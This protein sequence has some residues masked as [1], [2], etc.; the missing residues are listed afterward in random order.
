[1]TRGVE[2]QAKR[3]ASGDTRTKLVIRVPDW[4]LRVPDWAI[5]VSE[6]VLRAIR[7]PDWAIRV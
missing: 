4:A 5:R 7:V 3:Q 1:M 6:A 2:N